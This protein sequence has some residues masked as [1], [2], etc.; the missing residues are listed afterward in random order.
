MTR[1]TQDFRERRRILAYFSDDESK[2]KL[3]KLAEANDL[4]LSKQAGVLI[5]QAMES[6]P[7]S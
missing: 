7:V 5:E 2:E 6:R 4:S 1:N 3:K